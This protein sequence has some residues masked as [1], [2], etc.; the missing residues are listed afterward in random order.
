MKEENMTDKEKISYLEEQVE[1][2]NKEKRAIL[3]AIEFAGTVGNF[4]ISLNKIDS[5]AIIIRETSTRIKQIIDFKAFAFYLVNEE[6]SNFYQEFT[7]PEDY[8]SF[9][10]REVNHLIEDETFFWALTRNKPVTVSS[11]DK[12]G[13]IL[14][15]S[16]NTSSRT[17]GLFV[18][19][20]S[21]SREELT[22]LSLFLFSVTIIS[23]SNALESFEL[24]RQ[25]RD[26]K[27]QL[28]ENILQLEKSQEQLRE[29][30]E[31]YRAL[32]EQAGSSIILYDIET[33]KPVEFNDKAHENLGYTREEFTELR[34]EDYE[35][36][37][38]TEEIQTRIRHF[39]NKDLYS[40][41]TRHKRKD[42]QVRDMVVNSKCIHIHGKPYILSF[43]T[44][45]TE[46]KKSEVERK[47]LEKQLRQVQKMESIGTLAGGIAHDFNNILGIILGYA[48]LVLVEVPG[49]KNTLNKNVQQL[50]QAVDRA[51]RLVKQI[52]TFSHQGDETPKPLEV[53][54]I[55]K[56]A[57]GMLRSTLP[58]TIDIQHYVQKE[59]MTIL[60]NPTEVHQILMNLCTNAAQAMQEKAG[61]LKV[62]LKKIDPD[63]GI[64]YM[65]LTVSDTGD[66]IPP[67]ILERVFDPYFTTKKPGE[68]T[69][70]GLSVVHGI[71]KR[72]GGD[73]KIDT[74]PGK[75]TT[76]IVKIPLIEAEVKPEEV[77][78]LDIPIGDETILLVD[79]EEALL[80]TFQKILEQLNYTVI[81]VDNSPGALEIFRKTPSRFHLVI[82][83][84]TMPQMTGI[85][86]AGELLSLRPEIPIILCTGFSEFIDAKKAKAVGVKEFLMKPFSKRTLA[87]TI[88]RVLDG[89]S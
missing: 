35:I 49:K 50:I 39:L 14:L 37:Q 71:V 58:T 25:L 3:E 64:S 60:G 18:G 45:I 87:N 9:F 21:S 62:E 76:V 6:D 38:S 10:D 29:S 89:K 30:E 8:A 51:K 84:M 56:E 88:R 40:F 12:T 80:G 48:E 83:D 57:L 28:D 66:G 54:P 1:L 86:L 43:L 41:E 22:D 33:R 79:D 5:P 68:G 74:T 82:C 4:R 24:Y 31:K 81:T 59:S 46:R 19:I 15:H 13:Q 75:G 69:G 85:Q 77:L 27:K 65:L 70:L 26:K 55:I 67:D 52:L 34:I 11:L 32:F 42:G 47:A 23:C 73:I 63:T 20:L 44:D 7:D 17:R 72:Y 2:L 78:L 16:M 36:D 53:N 61:V